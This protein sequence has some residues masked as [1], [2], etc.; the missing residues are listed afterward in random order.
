[1]SRV[2]FFNISAYVN[3]FFKRV[4]ILVN[5]SCATRI[6]YMQFFEEYFD[7]SFS[8]TATDIYLH[9]NLSEIFEAVVGSEDTANGKSLI[10]IVLKTTR[11]D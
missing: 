11:A 4:P 9:D 10:A 5:D 7:R 3:L 6:S 1:M 8:R 2:K